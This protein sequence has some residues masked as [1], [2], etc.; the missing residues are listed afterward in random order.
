YEA[1]R[2]KKL[3]L[4]A[5]A[6]A[7]NQQMAGVATPTRGSAKPPQ[8]TKSAATPDT[9]S[10]SKKLSAVQLEQRLARLEEQIQVL[11]HQLESAENTP[12]ELEQIWNERERLSGE[13]NEMLAQWA[14][15]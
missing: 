13:Y 10:T 11:D 9:T 3:E 12:D 8:E 15:P 7:T 6:A 1:Y 2:E 14:E 4:Q 5:H